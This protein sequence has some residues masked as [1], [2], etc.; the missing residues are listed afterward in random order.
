M[1]ALQ[2]D[3]DRGDI[4]IVA[5]QWARDW[6]ASEALHHTENALTQANNDVVAIVA[7]NDATAVSSKRLKNRNSRV[8]F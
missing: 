3:I 1:K 5:D 8:K 7:S 4:K 6:L 2:P